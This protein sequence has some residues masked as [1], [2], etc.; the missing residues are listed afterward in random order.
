M[1]RNKDKLKD[2][3]N[4]ERIAREQA[5][6]P[7]V[8]QSGEHPEHFQ[9]EG[10]DADSF[11]PNRKEDNNNMGEEFDFDKATGKKE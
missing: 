3:E 2:L 4:K 1:D 11:H 10:G 8:Y 6:R 7:G 5:K 9:N